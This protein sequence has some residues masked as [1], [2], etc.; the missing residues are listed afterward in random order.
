MF[1]TKFKDKVDEFK[2][3]FSR[4]KELFDRSIE[5]DTLKIVHRQGE[6]NIYLFDLG[7]VFITN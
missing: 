2:K 5:L 1:S 3:E 7:R 4:A 6:R